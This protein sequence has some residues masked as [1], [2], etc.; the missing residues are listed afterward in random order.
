MKANILVRAKRIVAKG[1]TKGRRVGRKTGPVTVSDI[2][3]AKT[4][5]SRPSPN[6]FRNFENH[7]SRLNR[8]D[9]ELVIRDMTP[10]ADSNKFGEI[11]ISKPYVIDIF[12][13]GCRKLTDMPLKEKAFFFSSLR[14]GTIRL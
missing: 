1:S 7:I 11:R 8:V 2:S 4:V 5:G 13:S 14:L 10:V 3:K 12:W 9:D 6:T